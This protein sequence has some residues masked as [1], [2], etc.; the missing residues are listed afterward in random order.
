[1]LRFILCLRYYAT[2]KERKFE[3]LFYKINTCLQ[4][5]YHL[6]WIVDRANIF[7]KYIIYIFFNFGRGFCVFFLCF[8]QKLQFLV[9]KKFQTNF[10]CIVLLYLSAQKVCL[11]F[12]IF[13]FKLEILIFLS[14]VVSF[15]V[16][17][18]N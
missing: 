9:V 2:F 14:F 13:F 8:F 7:S 3:S 10:C 17:M 12:L 6:H 16:D 11:R 5:N 4:K 1:M 18:F 15:L